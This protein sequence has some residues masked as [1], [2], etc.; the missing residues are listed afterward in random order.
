MPIRAITIED[1]E[2]VRALIAQILAS[3]GFEV[4]GTAASGED[5]VALARQTRPDVALVD[6]GLP[7]MSGEEVIAILSRELPGTSCIVLTDVDNPARVL[8]AMR[9]GAVGY[10]LKP[11][12]AWELTHAVEDVLSGKAAPISQRAAKALLSELRSDVPS[13]R[14]SGGPGLSKRE[15]EVLQLL[16]HGHTYADVAHALGVAEGVVQTY[17]KRIYEKMETARREPDT[18][19]RALLLLSKVG[20]LAAL[21]ALAVAVC[22]R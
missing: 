9:A 8:A 6:L 10:I 11:F 1:D 5:G 19:E 13:Q 16:V 17:V 21:A 3:R 7:R 18:A 15:M 12:H 4:A 20:A 22:G 14:P 2:A